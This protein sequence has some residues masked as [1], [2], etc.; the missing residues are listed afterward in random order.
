LKAGVIASGAVPPSLEGTGLG[1]AP[2]LARLVGPGMGLELVTK[3]NDIPQGSRLAVSTNLLASIVTALM[4]ATGQTERLEGP[5]REDER[6]LVASR[7]IL[8]EWLGGSGGGWQDSGGIWPGIKLIEGVP[9]APGD[10]EFGSSRGRLLPS[11]RVMGDAQI[12]PEARKKLE[13]S[14]V[15]VHGGMAAN[16]G[17]ILEMVT[18]KFL[19][20]GSAEWNARQE[21]LEAFEAILA[22]LGAGDMKE[23][24][25]LTTGIFEGPLARI[26]PWVSNFY[27]EAL[28]ADARAAFGSQFWGFWMLGGMS[29]GG[30]GFIFDPAVKAEAE[31][32]M[33]EIMR[34]RKRELAE[35]LPFAMD[36]VVYR[37]SINDAGT[38]A[39]FLPGDSAILSAEYYLCMLPRWLLEGSRSFSEQRRAELD[40]FSRV[41]LRGERA[42]LVGPQLLGRLLPAVRAA[43]REESLDELLAQHGFDA[44]HHEH[45]KKDLHAGR[46]GLA[47]N[48]L[49]VDTVIEDVQPDQIVQLSALGDEDRRTGLAALQRGEV[50]L[51]T[52]AAGVG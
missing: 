20:G 44:D 18:E 17:P 52:L 34:K 45:I 23:L 49:P 2:V 33:L 29:G 39:E 8:G 36:P 25:R 35:S 38:A 27:T 32:R 30:M 50:C 28:I 4:R 47:K 12:S 40:V 46:I 43:D 1:V 19:L 22:A 13:A 42:E 24:G 6:R 7:A 37:F 16:V 5:L 21:L 51:I 11:H 31:R 14:L 10:V 15:V 3:V 26:V 9:A 48:R 41:H